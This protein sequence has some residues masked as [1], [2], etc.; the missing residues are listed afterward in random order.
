MEAIVASLELKDK[1][2]V[3]TQAY[4]SCKAL[5][6]VS[7]KVG[8]SLSCVC[9]PAYSSVPSYP[10]PADRHPKSNPCIQPLPPVI[11]SSNSPIIT[12]NPLQDL[13][14]HHFGIRNDT[15]LDDA[16]C[17]VDGK[18]LGG[19]AV[20]RV[21]DCDKPKEGQQGVTQMEA[22]VAPAN[23]SCSL[24]REGCSARVLGPQ[25]LGHMPDRGHW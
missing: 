25:R 15:H 17:V 20:S 10:N 6:W 11:P 19:R 3:S 23:T 16:A 5:R 2:K 22:T 4:G 14:K 24:L 18:I 9:C 8:V 7:M 1:S 12:E 13:H 21:C